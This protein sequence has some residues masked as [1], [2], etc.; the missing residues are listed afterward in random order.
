LVATLTK[1]ES[2]TAPAVRAVV[3]RGALNVKN[4][5]RQR[6]GGIGHAPALPAAVTYDV[7]YGFGSVSAEVGPD[8]GKRQGALGNIIEY[9]TS[10]NAPIPGGL[11]ALEAESPKFERALADLG[12]KS[13]GG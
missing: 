2:R 6:W 11:P 12:E 4:D 10:K 5:W 13:L 1:A 7:S 3:E 9:G 8:K